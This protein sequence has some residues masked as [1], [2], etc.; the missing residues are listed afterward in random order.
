MAIKQEDI[1]ED[2]LRKLEIKLEERDIKKTNLN[3]AALRKRWTRDFEITVTHT[4]RACNIDDLMATAL[5]GGINY[6]CGKVEV[7]EEP[8]IEYELSSEV[9]SRGGRLRLYDIEDP[10]E[11]WSLDIDKFINGLKC[12]M[13]TEFTS[14][15]DLMN[16][17]DAETTDILIQYALFNKIV[18]G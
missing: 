8:E 12:V 15:E 1:Y 14:V 17:Y 3:L 11:S 10:R 4:I 6:W 2:A 7:I 5:E 9:I 16:T 18:F 13:Q